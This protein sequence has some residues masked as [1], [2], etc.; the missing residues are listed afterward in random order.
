MLSR[1]TASNQDINDYKTLRDLLSSEEKERGRSSDRR[2]VSWI[3]LLKK[4][5]G[6]S[7]KAHE[8]IM[9]AYHHNPNLPAL[10]DEM[11]RA[12]LA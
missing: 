10:R 7:E 5:P 12:E 11:R 2:I 6:A 8:I 3:V 9:M 4:I 1:I